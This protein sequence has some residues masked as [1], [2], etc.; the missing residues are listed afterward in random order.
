VEYIAS[1]FEYKELMDLITKDKMSG[2]NNEVVELRSVIHMCPIEVLQDELYVKFV[3][4]CTSKKCHHIF[5]NEF[6]KTKEVAFVDEPIPD[7]VPPPVQKDVVE[8]AGEEEEKKLDE[9]QKKKPEK[10]Q[11]G[12]KN[13]KPERYDDF[14]K[15]DQLRKDATAGE[16]EG[17]KTMDPE[18]G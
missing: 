17:S 3:D 18:A 8:G 9:G 10:A 7:Y 14:K 6:L 5:V 11:K 2:V 1:L 12:K 15:L 16:E 13:P 4:S